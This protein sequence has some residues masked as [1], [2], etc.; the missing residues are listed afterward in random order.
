MLSNMKWM[1]MLFLLFFD[2]F[3]LQPSY[4]INITLIMILHATTTYY[5]VTP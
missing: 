3:L 5:G 2:F 1:G 4:I